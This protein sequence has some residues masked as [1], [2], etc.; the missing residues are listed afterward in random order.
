[1][2]ES[3][4]P[5]EQTKFW[6]T[7]TP[8]SK[9]VALSL[10]IILPLATFYLG[11]RYQMALTPQTNT[12][13]STKI[14]SKQPSTQNSLVIKSLSG[15]AQFSIPKDSV[16]TNQKFVVTPMVG[17][18]WPSNLRPAGVEASIELSNPTEKL[19]FLKPVTLTMNYSDISHLDA[20]SLKIYYCDN[21][22]TTNPTYSKSLLTEIDSKTKTASA[23][24]MSIGGYGLLGELKCPNDTSEYDDNYD[25]SKLVTMGTNNYRTLDSPTDEDWLR[26]DGSKG[27]SY[28]IS[29]VNRGS[30]VETV[31]ELYDP[32][33]TTLL[34]SGTNNLNVTVQN[35]GSFFA[36]IRPAANSSTGCAATYT[37]V[38]SEQ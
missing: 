9:F 17:C 37:L 8:F 34:G 27:R 28:Q 2:E 38:I 18:L 22:I 33:G 4:L 24:L 29:A 23:G 30:N 26:F 11:M 7:V 12:S 13:L 3:Q 16:S 20:N 14:T 10:F 36:R 32:D 35:S 25:F 1:M 31:V 6:T 21:S 5:S 19:N 15:N